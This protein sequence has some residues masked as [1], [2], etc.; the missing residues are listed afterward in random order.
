METLIPNKIIEWIP[1]NNLQNIE[2]LTRGGFSKIYT[3]DWIDGRYKEW[4]SNERKLIRYGSHEV[5]LKQLENVESASQSWFEEAK[6]HLTISNKYAEIVQCF[7]LTQDPSNGNYML[8]MR[9]CDVNLR[10][11]LQQNHDQFIWKEKIRITFLIINAFYWIHEENSIHRDLH[12]GNVL[13]SQLN[14]SWHISDLGF[15]GPAN[16]SSTCIYGNLPYIAPEVING[17][18]YTFKSDVYSI[19]MLMWEISSGQ[20]PFINYEHDCNLAINIINGMR[21]KII[22][23]IPSE[24][25]SLMEQCWD[26]DPLKRP[27]INTLR[28]KMNEIMSYYQNKPNELPQLKVKMDNVTNNNI[29]SKLFTSK[30]HKFENLPE[31]K[32][33]TKVDVQNDYDEREIMQQQSNIDINDEVQNNPKLHSEEQYEFEIPD[34]GF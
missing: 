27:D 21:P 3:A 8:V 1:Y 34:D 6:S 5:I 11:Y 23:E 24:Y 4:D 22:S 2:Y 26:A 20:L 13:Y 29:S 32:N 16:K 30:I 10:E 18:E 25:K 19:A 9:K 17:K 15:C 14:N 31:P 7:G 33:A 12:S 28:F